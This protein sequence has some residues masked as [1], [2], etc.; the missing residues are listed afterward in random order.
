[1]RPEHSLTLCLSLINEIFRRLKIISLSSIFLNYV[2]QVLNLVKRK[3][4]EMS[5]SEEKI[6]FKAPKR[7]NIRQRKNSSDE[8]DPEKQKESAAQSK[9][10][11]IHET[12]EKQ[13]LRTRA[14]GVNV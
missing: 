12:K 2:K 1:L 8:E 7:K 5:E 9:L 10:E 6:Q 14:N 4:T 11:L 13:K 3:Q